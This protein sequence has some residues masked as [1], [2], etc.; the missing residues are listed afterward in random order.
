ARQSASRN[1]AAA[2]GPH[3]NE[4]QLIELLSVYR[5]TK[6]MPALTRKSHAA[7]WLAAAAVVVVA[8]GTATMWMNAWRDGWR[9]LRSGQTIARPA[10][11]E[12]RGIGSVD[13]A[14]NTLLDFEGGNHF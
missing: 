2:G 7:W 14:A 10:R 4:E 13:V 11:I 9:I 12:R 1:G 5:H 8:T 6:P 3:V